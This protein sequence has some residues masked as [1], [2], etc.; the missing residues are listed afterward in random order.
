MLVNHI[1][2][3]LQEVPL[4]VVVLVVL[5]VVVGVEVIVVAVVVSF[6]HILVPVEEK[7]AVNVVSI[8]LHGHHPC[9]PRHVD[10]HL[11][12]LRHHRRIIAREEEEVVVDH[13]SVM[14]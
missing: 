11:L 5:V 4:R 9:L 12:I 13:I 6:H 14:M 10:I 8:I 2:H 1:I 7:E 3:H